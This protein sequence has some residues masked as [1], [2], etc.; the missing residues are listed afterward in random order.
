MKIC[1]LS[2][3]FTSLFITAQQLTAQTNTVLIFPDEDPLTP[4]SLKLVWPTTPGLRY[5]VQQST[6]LQ[7]WTTAPGFPASA[8]GPAQQMP[9][10]PS[11]NARFFQVKQLDEQPPIIA[12]QYPADGG[13]AVPRFA[14]LTMQLADATG[15][16]TN[17]IQLTVGSLGTF[18]LTNA[19]LTFSNNLLTYISG[20][21]IP[22]GG[23]GSNVQATLIIADTLGY[24]VTNIWNFTLEVQPQVVGNLRVFGSPQAQRTGQQIGNIPTAALAR[25]FG[26]IPMGA[27]DPW[28]LELVES[29]RLELSYTN[30]A[31]D[32]AANTYVC[33]LTP[34][35]TNEIF[36]RK[37]TSVSDNSGL[38]R[39]TLY[40]TNVSLAEILLEGSVSLSDKSAVYDVGTNGVITAA[41]SGDFA[42]TFGSVG[43]SYTNKTL[44]DSGGV[45]L[46]LKEA[47][48]LFTPSLTLSFETKFLSL[49][50]F[51]A[52]LQG[53][54]ETALIPE[55]TISG[56]LGATNEYPLFNSAPV[57]IYVGNAGPVPVWLDIS[58]DVTAEVGYALQADATATTGVRKELTLG[59]GVDYV[60]G[61]LPDQLVGG[62]TKPYNPDPV[63][64]PFTY[65]I[66][67]SASAY[68]TITP[69]LTVMVNSL[70]GMYAD[71]DPKV[72]FD[73]N[74]SFSGGQVQ[75][76]NL[77]LGAS[78]YLNVGLTVLLLGDFPLDSYEIFNLPWCTNYPPLGS[79]S[80]IDQP[81]PQ[82][83][84]VGSSATFT[85]NAVGP[86]LSYQWY[87]NNGT[88]M[89]GK[90]G[91][92][93]TLYNVTLGHQG[94][95]RVKVTGGGQ[96]RWSDPATLT[97]YT[98]NTPT[99][100]SLIPAGSFTMGDNLDGDS[101][102]LPL[103]TVYVSAFYMDRYE[104]TKALWDDVYNWATNHGYSFNF[105]VQGKSPTHP[106]HNI[107][108]FDAVKWCNAR[109]EKEGRTPAYFTSA[110]QTNVYRSGQVTVDNSWV[111][112]NVGYRL[113]TE[114][115]WEKAARGGAS[116]HRF[117]WADMSNITH[118]RANYFSSTNYTYDISSTRGYHPTFATGGNPYTS[119][120]GYFA[121]NGYGLYDMAG[122]V[123]EWCWDWY[124]S[125]Y[126]NS[127]PSTDPRGPVPASQR[128][129]RGHS[130]SDTANY[131]RTAS[132]DFSVPTLQDNRLGFRSVLPSGK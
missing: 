128:V 103:H 78:A 9:F 32:F 76:A 60:K 61:R 22:L 13:F 77:C 36:Y 11:G 85:V 71:V 73:G 20:G 30:T 114:A 70:A 82:Q 94:P 65:Q 100:M 113:A 74:A 2:L 67:G 41:I 15:I 129:Y 17:S 10:T 119:P 105:G 18:T 45:T 29:N 24:T 121:A 4:E 63:L 42:K 109:S 8:P 68:T 23:W 58:F 21:S 5:E 50:R 118:S 89:P 14:N 53:H 37:I 90:T 51:N 69:Q 80:I 62:P 83:A 49:Q 7:T 132:R 131:C 3:L 124:S 96:T 28:T 33:N 123:A 19:Q 31:P 48:F 1:K 107:T 86:S 98:A 126:Y 72:W 54:L 102:A 26:P 91:H 122:N 66:N 16:N 92:S 47:K 6:N 88:I 75:S 59:F 125:T 99:G 56:S 34:A 84:L 110:A 40:T 25:R 81:Q 43:F 46:T 52:Q 115:E 39:L 87:D 106:A 97:V 112:W 120:V 55:L 64:E 130:W 95:Y 101:S 35:T 12:S 111:K 79:L 116:G 127:S 93:L 57:L 108:W 117:P 38:K 44:L 104:V 27:G